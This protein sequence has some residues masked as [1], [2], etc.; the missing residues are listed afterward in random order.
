MESDCKNSE[1]TESTTSPA[2]AKTYVRMQVIL[3]YHREAFTREVQDNF[4]IAI[5]I[6]V[7][8]HHGQVERRVLVHK[9]EI[10]DHCRR[11]IILD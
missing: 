3:P 9:R 8:G 11:V 6:A 7:V 2:A 4:R 5:A 1:S 10:I